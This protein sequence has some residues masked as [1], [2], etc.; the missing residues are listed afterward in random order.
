M[1]MRVNVDRFLHWHKRR[2]SGWGRRIQIAFFPVLF[3]L[4]VV[5]FPGWLAGRFIQIPIG[6]PNPVR[7]FLGLSLSISGLCLY[8]WTIVLFAQARGTQVPIAPTQH[9]VTTGPYAVSRNPMVTSGIIM[10]I[11]V[12]FT[13]NSWSFVLAG[14]IPPIPYCIYIKL[15][16]ERELEARFGKEY[17]DYKNT[18]P[19]IIPRLGRN[20]K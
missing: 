18:T 5:L 7:L 13:I 6:L 1:L 10:V 11:G 3:L 16:E 2:F 14:L 15:V 4:F 8:L 20:K 9:I 19:F 17:A 12:G